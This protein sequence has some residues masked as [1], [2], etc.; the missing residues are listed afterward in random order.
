MP[1]V[2]REG[3]PYLEDR[4]GGLLLVDSGAS[5]TV[6]KNLDALEGELAMIARRCQLRPTPAVMPPFCSGILGYDFLR[7]AAQ[8]GVV[9]LDGGYLTNEFEPSGTCVE[10]EDDLQLPLVKIRVFGASFCDSRAIVDTGS[11]ITICN[12][13]LDFEAVLYADKTGATP[14]SALGVDGVQTQLV[15]K[16]TSKVNIAAVVRPEPT[17]YVGDLAMFARY[18]YAT[19]PLALLGSDIL[20]DRIAFDFSGGGST[21]TTTTSPPVKKKKTRGTAAKEPVVAA[22]RGPVRL[23]LP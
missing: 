10:L 1:L 11:P 23:W 20:G 7:A 13:A 18:G 22:A 14:L 4:A 19:T 6:I 12:P 3:L 15:R 16:T 9:A 17:V 8:G 5:V 2:L 21:T